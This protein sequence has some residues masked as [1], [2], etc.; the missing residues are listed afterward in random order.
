MVNGTEQIFPGE[1]SKR[2]FSAIARAN[3]A[4]KIDA[5]QLP[6]YPDYY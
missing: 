1:G 3:T 6:E 2:P 4:E 5:Q